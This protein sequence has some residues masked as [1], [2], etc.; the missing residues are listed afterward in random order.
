[1]FT[2]VQNRF[3]VVA[4]CFVVLCVGVLVSS[5]G[6]LSPAKTPEELL[7]GTSSKTWSMTRFVDNTGK[8][9]TSDFVSYAVTFEK[10]GAYSERG[11]EKGKS[12][13]SY[14]GTWTIT[15]SVSPN[16]LQVRIGSSRINYTI[17]ELSET[18]LVLQFDGS[19]G[20]ITFKSN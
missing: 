1:M 5:C 6:L 9:I 13:E 14:T 15:T 7:A 11:Q 18:N 3:R 12:V 16:T 8:D 2:A 19:Q 10:S 17:Q 4:M 20:R